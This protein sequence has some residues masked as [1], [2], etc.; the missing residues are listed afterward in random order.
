MRIH[1]LLTLTVS[2]ICSVEMIHK[3]GEP[4]RE[5]SIPEIEQ[6]PSEFKSNLTGRETITAQLPPSTHIEATFHPQERIVY[7]IMENS[8]VSAASTSFRNHLPFILDPS[9]IWLLISQGF[10]KH[11]ILNSEELRGQIVDFEGKEKITVRRD[12]FIMGD[13][14]NDWEGVFPEFSTKIGEYIGKELH[15][16]IRSDFSTT[17]EVEKTVSEITL[18]YAMQKYFDY[19]V[20]TSCGIP[21]FRIL[22]T[23]D[24]WEKI[25]QK[26]M[27]L[28]KYKLEWWTSKLIPILDKI[29]DIIR[30]EPDI[31][32]WSSFYKRHSQ[33]GGDAVTGWILNFFPYIHDSPNSKLDEFFLDEEFQTF[34]SGIAESAIPHGLAQVPFIWNYLGVEYRMMFVGGFAGVA[35]E[36]GDYIRPAQGWAVLHDDDDDTQE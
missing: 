31:K 30:Y 34:Y 16:L 23:V 24:D 15:S 25:K 10:G 13:E 2:I 3:H 27:D 6:K 29:I 8:F 7:S 5:F 1:L 12:Q 19:E 33:S 18:M 17:G 11:I 22:G 14:G 21:G 26:T 36:D 32:F 9:D 4:V 20:M 35:L 28:T